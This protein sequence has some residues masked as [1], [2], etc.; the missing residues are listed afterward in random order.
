MIEPTVDCDVIPPYEVGRVR[1]EE[2]KDE[3]EATQLRRLLALSDMSPEQQ[4]ETMMQIMM[5]RYLPQNMQYLPRD[6]LQAGNPQLRIQPP[7]ALPPGESI[8]I[9]P[10]NGGGGSGNAGGDRGR[11][12]DDTQ[13]RRRL[14][15]NQ[16]DDN[17]IDLRPDE[18]DPNTYRTRQ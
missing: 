7:P 2:L 3:Q 16:L 12:K 6:L 8:T 10:P 5:M 1:R 15:L 13:T 14:N 9:Q 4:T 18:D 17:V 11:R